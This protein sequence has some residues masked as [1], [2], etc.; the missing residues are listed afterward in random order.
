MQLMIYLW[1]TYDLLMKWARG[2]VLII[3]MKITIYL[4][5]LWIL[6]FTYF[7]YGTYANYELLII[8]ILLKI[9]LW[10]TYDP[11]M[12]WARGCVLIILRKN[13]TYLLYLWLLM[14]TYCTYDTYFTYDLLILLMIYLWFTYDPLMKWATGGV[15]FILRKNT[16]YLLYLWFFR[17]THCTYHT[18]F[19]Y[20]FLYYL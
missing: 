10:F 1:F 7:T 17:I 8:L 19:T 16:A 15:L 2:G 14:F 11:L 12:K 3:L 18:Y 13:T 9:Y 4:V 20:E 5:Y 6:M